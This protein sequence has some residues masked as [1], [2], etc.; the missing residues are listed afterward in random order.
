MSDVRDNNKDPVRDAIYDQ[1]IR[2]ERKKNERKAST[3]QGAKLPIKREADD[4]EQSTTIPKE[5]SGEKKEG[6]FR[7]KVN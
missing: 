5:V 4:S 6:A 3:K 7:D 1:T 2:P